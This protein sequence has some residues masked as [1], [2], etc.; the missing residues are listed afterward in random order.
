MS[1]K[2]AR[3]FF[4]I[5]GLTLLGLSAQATELALFQSV[6]NTD[7][8]SAGIS[9]LRKV[10]AGT[11]QVTNV[12]GTIK[13]AYLYW[14][15]PIN[16]LPGTGS[17]LFN[18]QPV[19]GVNIGISGNNGWTGFLYSEAFRAD[20][21]ALVT[22]SGNY[23][24][25]NFN[26]LTT[27]VEGAS[28]IILF[29]DGDATNNRDILLFD[30]NDSTSVS[31]LDR[32]GWNC[33]LSGINYTPSNSVS[34]QLHVSDGQDYYDGDVMLNGNVIVPSGPLFSGTSLPFPPAYTN[35][36]I[37][38]G[39]TTNYF[40]LFRGALWDIQ[41]YDITSSLSPGL[42]GLQL[43][44][45]QRAD[46]VSLIAVV[47]D[48]ATGVPPP[49]PPPNNQPPAITGD[50]PLTIELHIGDTG[51]NPTFHVHVSDVDG[52]PLTVI[53]QLDGSAI[54]AD[55]VPSGGTN[56]SANLSVTHL[57]LPGNH[58]LSVTVSDGWATPQIFNIPVTVIDGIVPTIL[59]LPQPTFK[60]DTNGN[61]V[62][63]DLT[64]QV[65]AID[66]VT[67]SNLLVIAQSPASGN[68]TTL[69]THPVTVVVTDQALNST[70]GYTQ[71][72][73]TD[74]V[75]P[76][77]VSV[78]QP[79]V[80]SDVNGNAVVPNIISQVVA[81][82]N[83]TPANSLVITQSPIGGS[84]ATVGNQTLTVTVTDQNGNSSRALVT[85]VVGDGVAPRIISMP[86]PIV[87]ADSAG[88]GSVPNIVNQVVASDNVTPANLLVI[89]QSPAAG[90]P[91]T[92][93]VHTLTVVVMD[94][95]SNKTT[96]STTFTVVDQSPPTIVSIPALTVYA[97]TNGVG[98]VPAITSRVVAFDNVTPSNL[99]V[100][101]QS[102][103]A[104]ASV[105]LGTWPISV[106][107]RDQA[108]NV[109]TGS[110]TISV[111]PA[112]T[113]QPPVVICSVGVGTL[114]PPNHD[115]VNVGFTATSQNISDPLTVVVYS[116]EPDTTTFSSDD[117]KD[118]DK[119]KDKDS[120]KEKDKNKD[121]DKDKDADKDKD[122]Q[123]D[124][125]DG[126]DAGDDSGKNFSPDAKNIGTS[127]LRL[128]RELD[129]QNLNGRVYL[130]VV[131]GVNSIGQSAS[132]ASTVG[133]PHDQSPASLAALAANT[134]AAVRYFTIN[135]TPPPGFVVVG[136]GPVIGPK[137]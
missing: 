117:Q 6:T 3:S 64:G 1:S 38:P 60:T 23:T 85:F 66:N 131:T 94:Q 67:P 34:I 91:T 18:G 108:G 50:P 74:G 132:C 112:P 83:V 87:P 22:G 68:P 4:F 136:T 99:L 114:W 12:S 61:A 41:S 7:W 81:S 62:I 75:P 47:V 102:P 40:N 63:P 37:L 8:A 32:N 42:N 16:A 20:V 86:T 118:K 2:T 78:P 124:K 48:Q 137:Q 54:H 89:S 58:L 70:V 88:G 15:G 71:F 135:G 57:L 130:I 79:S 21:T 44:S 5:L 82:D 126:K 39:V 80:R 55:T 105:A 116:N 51:V 97:N 53:W 103:V 106:T 45:W 29:D 56:T 134:T 109:A 30:G 115:L 65:F 101:A 17:L 43:T 93:G 110:S 35:F 27:E 9:G 122:K 100:I 14:A 104:G 13:K 90:T 31:G 46:C 26:P 49:Q 111:L 121:N 98:L 92:L 119:D 10:G 107:V 84:I 73:V 113:N 76:T 120:E 69:G 96:N 28:L 133:V 127:G 128:R 123:K 36:S 25:S 11:I 52:N 24:V 19:T 33:F 129:G 125:D 72:T 95:A 77:I 59:S